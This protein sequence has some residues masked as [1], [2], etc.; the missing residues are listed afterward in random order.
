MKKRLIYL[1]S[2]VIIITGAACTNNYS[3]AI[4]PDFDR[5]ILVSNVLYISAILVITHH[6]VASK[7]VRNIF[8]Y[9]K[10]I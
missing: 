9:N 4:D 2:T 6:S 1:I 5:L 3:E 8:T 7:D 10:T